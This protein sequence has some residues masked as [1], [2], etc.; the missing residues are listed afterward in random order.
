LVE[1]PVDAVDEGRK[2]GIDQ[3]RLDETE[4]RADPQT[5]EVPLL[6]LARIVVEEAVDPDH[7][8]TAGDEHV[9]ESRSDES[10]NAG[11]QC[12]HET[13]SPFLVSSRARPAWA[14]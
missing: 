9:G 10:G 3:A 13:V 2:V 7:V 5:G 11:D 1:D 14:G 4:L 8:V 6:D 12:L